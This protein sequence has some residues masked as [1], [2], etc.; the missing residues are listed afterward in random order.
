[1]LKDGR[2]KGIDLGGVWRISREE[3]EGFIK[4]GGVA[5]GLRK[6]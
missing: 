3:L 6:P 4:R 5:E 2:L 1:M